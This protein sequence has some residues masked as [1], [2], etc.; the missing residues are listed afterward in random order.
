MD[1]DDGDG[2]ENSAISQRI[3]SYGA[4]NDDVTKELTEEK[5]RA[6]DVLR[7]MFGEEK[8]TVLT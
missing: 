4:T 1:D 7:S 5:L 3:L 2:D 8:K 6:M